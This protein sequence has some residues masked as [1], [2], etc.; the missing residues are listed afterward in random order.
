M[1]QA[2]RQLMESSRKRILFLWEQ[3]K[4]MTSRPFSLNKGESP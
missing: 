4:S 1:I 3:W 2:K